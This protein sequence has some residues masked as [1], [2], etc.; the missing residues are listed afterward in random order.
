M[1]QARKKSKSKYDVRAKQLS[2]DSFLT[3]KM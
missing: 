3:K 2:I 1:K